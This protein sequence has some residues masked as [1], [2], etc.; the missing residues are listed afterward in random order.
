MDQNKIRNFCI[1]AHIDHGKSTLAD[2]LLEITNTV[3]KRIMKEQYLDDMELEREKGI[4]IK[5]RPVKMEYNDFILNLIDTPGHVDFNYEVSRSLAAVEGALL[6]VDAS[7]GV[8]AQ[9]LANL[10]LA[11]EEN[12][13]IIPI[14]NKIDLKQADVES[15]KKDLIKILGCSESEIISI[16]AK[17]G[18]GIEKILETI[19]NIIPPPK[20]NKNSKVQALIF[21]SSYDDYRGVI[22][23]IKLL[24]GSL[25]IN[26]K[27]KLVA[28]AKETSIIDMGYFKPEFVS[29]KKL[30]A[31]EIGYLTTGIK[32]ITSANVGDTITLCDNQAEP[33][34]GYREVRPMVYAGIF[35]Q[36]GSDYQDLRQAIE[37]LKLNDAALIYQ[38]ENSKSL[39]FGFRCGFLGILHL[40]IFQ[41][42]L[43]REFNLDLI[44]TPPSVAYRIK[45][46]TG[47]EIV[48][49]NPQD[50]PDENLISE[51]LEP[52]MQIEIVTP[53]IYQGQIMQYV[54]SQGGIF[55]DIEYL[56]SQKCIL[57]YFLHLSSIIV[58][59]YDKIKSVSSGY[60]SLNY[61]FAGYQ[62]VDLVKLD[63]LIAEKKQESLSTLIQRK[64]AYEKARQ[65]VESLKK[66]IPKKL[67]EIKIQAAIGGK[68]IAASRISALRKDVIAKLYGGDVTRKKKLLEKQK[69]GKK[70][71]RKAG[72]ITIPADIYMAIFKKQ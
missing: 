42:R 53:R 26:D 46:K 23:Y 17:T 30:E 27:I 4:T 3:S 24:N 61:E 69:K 14:I 29:T 20:G 72:S 47:K 16:S 66:V 52:K 37:K 65:I 22:V 28:S 68:I 62:K 34:K 9:T 19:V 57:R 31:G 48:I 59:F 1:I 58:D 15:T 12:L 41:E 25:N 38:P 6:V 50:Y 21:D 7:Q 40:E 32:E 10:H 44:I 39:G 33:L 18:Q 2:R 56:D 43:K 60:A 63:I 71:M 64:K 35:C 45:L 49:K 67:F 51:T 36:E 70:R 8:Q 13:T 5:L 54:Q 11:I 55:K